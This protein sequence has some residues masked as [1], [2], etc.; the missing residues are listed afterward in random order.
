MHLAARVHQMAEG[1]GP[2]SFYDDVNYV[3]SL[4]LAKI[5]QAQGIRRMIFLSSIKVNGEERKAPYRSD[6]NPNPVDPYGQS[7]YKAE[8]GL[9]CLSSNSGLGLVIIRPPLVYGVGVKANFAQLVRWVKNKVPLPLAGIN[10]H[11]S[12]VG[13][14]NLCDLIITCLQSPA[15]VGQTLLVSD[16][17]TVSTSVLVNRIAKAYGVKARL[18][19]LPQTLLKLIGR[20]IGKADTVERLLGSLSVDIEPT[21][22]LL[23]WHPP[24]TMQETLD[25]MARHER[26]TSQEVQK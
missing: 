1:S 24:V 15:A 3:G 26:Q 12:M 8:K 25:L 17:E 11:R 7:K 4:N 13:I 18:F 14:D 5:A 10:N 6:D 23:N 21:C 22:R 20:L 2:T 16:G 9:Q 19:W